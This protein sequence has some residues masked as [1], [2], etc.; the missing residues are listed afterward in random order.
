MTESKMLLSSRSVRE[1]LGISD[2]TLHRWIQCG[3]L[4]APDYRFGKVFRWKTLTID[5]FLEQHAM[6]I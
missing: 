6:K 3:R 1:A 4:P 2:K 5:R